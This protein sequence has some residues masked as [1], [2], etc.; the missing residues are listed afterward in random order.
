MIHRLDPRVKIISTFAYLIMLFFVKDLTGYVFTAVCLAAV[1]AASHVP[2]RFIA[3]GMKPVWFILAFTF[4]MNL[5]M[6]DGTIIWRLGPLTMTYEGLRQAVYISVRLVLL[7]FGA[8]LLTY[9]TKPLALTDGFEYILRPFSKFGLPSHEIAMMM[10]IA[11]RFIPT[12]LTETDKIMKAQQARGA[13]FESG[14]LLHRAKSMI[15]LLVP[16][17]VNAFRIAQ[18]LAMAMEARC[19]HG[20]RGRTKL[21]PMKYAGRDAAAC[22]LMAAFAAFVVIQSRGLLPIP[23]IWKV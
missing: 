18:D 11:L 14:N 4:V 15:P 5:F 3:R 16:L 21:H 22:V 6:Y 10:S 19:Y 8:S 20:G 1:I 17:F 23:M 7:V 12:L 9:T 2:L 13:D